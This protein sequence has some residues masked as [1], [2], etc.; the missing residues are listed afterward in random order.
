[1]RN[2]VVLVALLSGCT[3]NN[4]TTE[5][6]S[7]AVEMCG[8]RPARPGWSAGFSGDTATMSKADYDAMKDWSDDMETW[9]DCVATL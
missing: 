8:D 5:P 3:D 9:A 6:K 2:L 1:M 7:A 4:N